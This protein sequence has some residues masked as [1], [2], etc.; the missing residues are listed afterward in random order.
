MNGK[1]VELVLAPDWGSFLDSLY[2]LLLEAT[3]HS[4]TSDGKIRNVSFSKW[5]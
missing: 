4:L 3:S 2:A 1:D 5:L